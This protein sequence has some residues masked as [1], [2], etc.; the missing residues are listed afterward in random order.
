MKRRK[1]EQAIPLHPS[2]RK[3]EGPPESDASAQNSLQRKLHKLKHKQKHKLKHKHKQFGGTY[4]VLLAFGIGLLCVAAAGVL[5]AVCC[6]DVCGVLPFS[7]G[8]GAA[9]EK[10]LAEAGDKRRTTLLRMAQAQGSAEFAAS[11][12]S[13]DGR[14]RVGGK[15]GKQGAAKSK[16]KQGSKKP[17]AAAGT[18]RSRPFIGY[19]LD[20][21]KKGGGVFLPEKAVAFPADAEY[22]QYDRKTRDFRFEDDVD[23]P[24]RKSSGGGRRA[25]RVSLSVAEVL[26]SAASPHRTSV[27]QASKGS[28]ASVVGRS[29]ATEADPDVSGEFY[30]DPTDVQGVLLR[31]DDNPAADKRQSQV[32]LMKQ[33]APAKKKPA[34]AKTKQKKQIESTFLNVGTEGPT[35]R[36]RSSAIV[37]RGSVRGSSMRSSSMSSLN[38]RGSKAPKKKA[39]AASKKR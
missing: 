17:V 27:G 24:D 20:K 29:T 25:S 10:K 15:K 18:G 26:V 9:R 34:E 36:S 1:K 2:H 32:Q 3:G 33:P 38:S 35:S 4:S 37:S 12:G 22:P 23:S 5:V 7:C 31:T 16:A 14:A 6:C 13:S 21:R 8:P 11:D 30:S 28:R 19:G 39:K